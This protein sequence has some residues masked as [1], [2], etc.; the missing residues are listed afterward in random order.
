MEVLQSTAHPMSIFGEYAI[1]LYA[2]LE[3]NFL[4]YYILYSLQYRVVNIIIWYSL[5]FVV[6]EQHFWCE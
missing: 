3:N 5:L 4:F 2:N 6:F 1:I